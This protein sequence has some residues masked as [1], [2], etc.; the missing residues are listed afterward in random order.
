MPSENHLRAKPL[1]ALSFVVIMLGL[2][3]CNDSGLPT[4]SVRGKI[5]FAGGPPPKPGSIAFAPMSVSEGLPHR[6]G[7]A[8]FGTDGEFQVTSFRENDGLIPG[9]YQASVDCWLQ[10][11]N[12]SVPSTFEKY[13]AVPKDFHPEPITVDPEADVVEVVIDVPK[14]K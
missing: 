1:L 6:P 11:P 7:M 3:G 13:N 14:K 8:N 12:P 9:T 10:N 2:A 4:V 5:T